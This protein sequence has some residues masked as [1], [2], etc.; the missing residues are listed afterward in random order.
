[1]YRALPLESRDASPANRARQRFTGACRPIRLN[2][3]GAL[4]AAGLLARHRPRLADDLFGANLFVLAPRA[5]DSEP[6]GN[7]PVAVR[8]SFAFTQPVLFPIKK[9][10]THGTR[11]TRH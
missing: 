9:G 2:F 11:K 8:V 3:V 1:M 6:P 10:E 5:L 7:K 4:V